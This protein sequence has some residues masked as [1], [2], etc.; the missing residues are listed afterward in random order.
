MKI[1]GRCC[2]RSI[3]CKAHHV[4]WDPVGSH[5]IQPCNSSSHMRHQYSNIFSS[6]LSWDF[7]YVIT[8]TYSAWYPWFLRWWPSLSNWSKSYPQ[9]TNPC[10]AFRTTSRDFCK[11]WC[12]QHNISISSSESHLRISMFH[13]M[14][15]SVFVLSWILI[16]SRFLSSG[17]GGVLLSPS[18][19]TFYH[20]IK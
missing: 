18:F 17:V 16:R 19:I 11:S 3:Q 12:D 15:Y 10:Q 14:V 8:P 20:E 7:I 4:G 13:L 6:K 9:W 1:F 2:A 5:I